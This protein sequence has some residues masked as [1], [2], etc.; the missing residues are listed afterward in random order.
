VIAA[1]DQPSLQAGLRCPID[2]G[3]A[4]VE[5][6]TVVPAIALGFDVEHQDLGEPIRHF[7]FRDQVVPAECD[8]IDPELPRRDIDQPLAEE[9]RFKLA[10]RPVG[11]EGVLLVISNETSM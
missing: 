2:L 8:P 11:A 5:R 7:G 1:I 6:A 9:I 3:Q 10:R 4:A